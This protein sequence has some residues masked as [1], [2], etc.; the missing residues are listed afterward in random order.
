M[1]NVA[2]TD[3][4]SSL[5]QNKPFLLPFRYDFSLSAPKCG[6]EYILKNGNF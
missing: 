5:L 2:T 4:F 6:C 1:N 3:T